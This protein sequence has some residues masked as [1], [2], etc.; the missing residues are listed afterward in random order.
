[1]MIRQKIEKI[2]D[3]A[4]RLNG[5]LNSFLSIERSYALNPGIGGAVADFGD[6]G[7]QFVPP[8]LPL[9]ARCLCTRFRSLGHGQSER[10]RQVGN[11]L[12]ALDLGTGLP[13][14]WAA[15]SA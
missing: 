11:S 13:K 14:L 10:V 6:R 15:F 7:G 9:S 2:L 4:E 12:L 1:M 8:R 5:Q 3:N